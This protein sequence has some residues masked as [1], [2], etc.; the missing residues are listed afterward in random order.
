MLMHCGPQHFDKTLILN[1]FCYFLFFAF[2]CLCAQTAELRIPASQTFY[3]KLTKAIRSA[4]WGT[5]QIAS[6]VHCLTNQGASF[7]AGK[8]K[9]RKRR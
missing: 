5:N 9:V 6:R 3:P 2:Y 8:Y 4:L 1:N 7:V